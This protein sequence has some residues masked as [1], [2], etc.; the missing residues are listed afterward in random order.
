MTS[1]IIIVPPPTQPAF[2][3]YHLIKTCRQEKDK[4]SIEQKTMLNLDF[5]IRAPLCCHS[6]SV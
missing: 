6:Y 3:L 1:K 4:I 2:S 5:N